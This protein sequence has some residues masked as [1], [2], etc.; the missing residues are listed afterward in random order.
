MVLETAQ[1]HE[2]LV[3]ALKE[4]GAERVKSIVFDHGDH[5]FSAYRIALAGALV[6]W[7]KSECSR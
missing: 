1:H 6:Q 7:L 2:P 3:K 4:A 5:A